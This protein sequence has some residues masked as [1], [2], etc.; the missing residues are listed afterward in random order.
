MK[1]GQK[2]LDNI[3]KCV[4]KESLSFIIGAGFS[5]NISTAFPL[6]GDLLSPLAEKLYP[7]CNVKNKEKKK[8]NIERVIAEKTYLGIASEYV[9]RAGYHEAIDLYIEQKMPYLARR[10]DGGYDLMLYGS[11][12]DSNPSTECH[13]KLLAL[14]AKHIFTFNYDNTLDIL[15]DVDASGKLLEQHNQADQIIDSYQ[16]LLDEYLTEYEKLRDSITYQNN[17][18]TKNSESKGKKIDYAR[19]NTIIERFSLGLEPFRDNTPDFQALYQMHTETIRRE[20]NRQISISKYA[21]D[22]RE[23][24]YQLVTNAYQISLTDECRN[25]YKLHGNLRTSADMRYEFDGDKHMQYVIT[26]EDYD[27]YPK[28]HEAFVNL[29]R[30]SLLK[31]SFCLIGFSGDDLNFLT[32]IDWVK[33]ILDDAASKHP[34]SFRSIYY[35]NAD[36]K[37]LETPKEQLLQH[38]YIEVV[39]LYEYFPCAHTQQERISLFLDHLHRDKD[40]YNVYNESWEKINIE[41]GNLQI[42]DTLVPEIENVYKLSMYNR[43]PNQFGIAH[44]RR[45]SIFS[46]IKQI[47]DADINPQ[48]R[49]KMIYSAIIGELMPVNTVLSPTQIRYL[50]RADSELESCYSRLIVICQVLNGM[51]L[52]DSA[53]DYTYEMGLSH[54]FNLC[55]DDAKKII[56]RWSPKEGIDH[57]RRFLLQSV[58]NGE[59]DT[60]AITRLII[61]PD[62]FSCLQEYQHALDILP[63]IRG[64]ITKNKDR[65]MTMYGDLQQQTANLSR[66]NSHLI[67][68]GEQIN[69]LLNEIAQNKTQP[70][71]NIKN[72]IYFG[73]YNIPLVNSTKIL[74]MLVEL[75][76]PSEARNIILI[77]KGK[78]LTICENLYEIYPQPCLYFSLLYGNNKDLLRRIAQHYIYSIKLKD[79]LPKLLIMMLEAL[80][81]KSC[82]INVTEAIYIVAP[83]FMRA[84]CANKWNTAFENVY[85][86]FSLMNLGESRMATNEVQDFIITGIELSN[87]NRFKHAVLLQS[88]QLQKQIKDIHNRLV[89]A[90]SYGIEPNAEECA[91]LYKLLKSAET[92][93]HMYVLMNMSKWIGRESVTQKL[94]S[95]PDNLYQDCTLLEAAC[96]YAQTDNVFQ[97]RLKKIILKSPRLW[98]TGIKDN[99]S[100]VSHYGYTLGICDIQQY[101]QFNDEEIKSLYDSLVDAYNKID[102]ITREWD[103]RKMW[104]PFNDWSYILVEM[105]NF[106]RINK[107]A[108]GNETDYTTTLRSVTRLLNQ[109]RGGNSIS[110]LLVDDDKTGKAISWLVNEI[111]QQGVRSFQY[112]YMLIANKILTRHSKYLNSCFIHFGWALTKY[113]DGYDKK[114]FKPLLESILNLYKSY[115]E[116]KNGLNWNLE[117]AEK[118]I[119]EEELSKIYSVYKSWGGHI[120][121]WENYTPRYKNDRY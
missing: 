26:Q 32:W 90:A 99:C 111:H 63:Q 35:I 6:W 74:Q 11:V 24:K 59:Q 36:D 14:K 96:Q 55:F 25:I 88:L 115:Y 29:M 8:Q 113:A 120:K 95:L 19:I 104:G 31:G 44:Y 46:K 66:R 30:I 109:G 50:S 1:Q 34:Q 107:K 16:K 64:I 51:L 79:S 60:D 22:Q 102:T 45:S 23:D 103:G 94:Q 100:S 56:D 33:D 28:K 82:P 3:R 4:E 12:I 71:G 112:E 54:L 18:S 92:P 85:N 93:A 48:L 9:R 81:N 80:L 2:V 47:I 106:L 5:K 73:H 108:L 118:N 114:L 67:K 17:S 77:D 70:F 37:K 7:G 62:N 117:Y 91:E 10:K 57:M 84:V 65:G 86:T 121:F 89:I 72:T 76:V 13:K 53:D 61:N 69:R 83:F 110:S 78:W 52:K 58:Y 97:S 49:S 105:Q 21:R 87:C 27:S 119:V 75:G 15:A 43:I 38:H 116:D 98:Q 41:R 39:N 42:I 20:I 68:F 40:I 101:I